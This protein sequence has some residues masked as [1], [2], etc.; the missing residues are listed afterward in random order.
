MYFAQR[1]HRVDEAGEDEEDG[2]NEAEARA[3]GHRSN[4]DDEV[5]EN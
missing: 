3:T 1:R 2:D 5:D 4:E